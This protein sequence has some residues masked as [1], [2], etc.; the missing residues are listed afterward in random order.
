MFGGA[1][2]FTGIV[3]SKAEATRLT[4]GV[5]DAKCKAFRTEVEATRYINYYLRKA[6][7]G[8]LTLADLQAAAAA[9]DEIREAKVRGTI[10]RS[11]Y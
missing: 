8:R 5:A 10:I 1:E 9:P 11:P 3:R 7:A 4:R 2:G 6:G